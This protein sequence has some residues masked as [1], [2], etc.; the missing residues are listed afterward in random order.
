[1]RAHK[2]MTRDVMMASIMPVQNC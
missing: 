1:M 2:I